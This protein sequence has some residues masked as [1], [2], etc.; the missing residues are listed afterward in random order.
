MI[1]AVTLD[2]KQMKRLTAK[3]PVK[4]HAWGCTGSVPNQWQKTMIFTLFMILDREECYGIS[5][6]VCFVYTYPQKSQIFDKF[7]KNGP[8][9]I[10]QKR[11][12]SLRKA[13]CKQT[14]CACSEVLFL[15]YFGGCP[16]YR[17]APWIPLC[18]GSVSLSRQLCD[19]D[20]R[21]H[22]YSHRAARLIA[23]YR[24]IK[25]TSSGLVSFEM[26]LKLP[27]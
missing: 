4:D 8:I 27:S 12:G 19:S 13:R 24:A 2:S 7:T 14:H 17:M 1:S 23:N 11:A 25:L 22:R 5:N 20:S 18:A 15:V 9:W 6:N 26:C 21:Q 3:L 10:I 16:L